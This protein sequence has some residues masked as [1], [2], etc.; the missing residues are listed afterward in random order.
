MKKL[1]GFTLIEILV[2]I[3]IIFILAAILLPVI[4]IARR[5]AQES[6]CISNLRQLG[7]AISM[8]CTDY[9]DKYPHALHPYDKEEFG[10]G[11]KYSIEWD[12]LQEVPNMDTVLLPYVKQKEIFR[13]PLDSG[14]MYPNVTQKIISPSAFQVM[15][16]S[17]R[18]YPHFKNE[19]VGCVSKP[20]EYTLLWDV[21]SRWH[22]DKDVLYDQKYCRLF[23]DGHAKCMTGQPS[24]YSNEDITE[25]PDGSGR[26]N[27]SVCK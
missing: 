13:C 11:T 12:K 26:I 1:Y 10:L 23:Y 9:D 17:Y 6:S 24:N 7:L 5:K 18:I 3:T 14:F 20:S 16:S 19:T 25:M 15:G 27:L 4:T 22:G 21:V 8:Y 2:V